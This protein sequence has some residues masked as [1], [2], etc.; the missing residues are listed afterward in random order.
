MIHT[1]TVHV[2][3]NGTITGSLLWP[4]AEVDASGNGV[5]WPGYRAAL[6]G[7]TPDWENLV[8]DPA[9]YGYGLRSG[10]TIDVH[11]NPTT[12]VSVAYPAATAACGEAPDNR[13]SSLVLDKSASTSFVAAGGTFDYTIASRNDGLG[14]VED[15]V[16]TDPVPGVL[17]ILSVTP[18][19]PTDPKAPAW[20]SCVVTARQGDGYGGTVTCDLDRPLGSGV[21]APDIVLH[22]QLS[23][24]APGGAIMNVAQLT[25]K[26]SPSN[27][28]VRPGGLTTF[29]LTDDAVILSAAALAMTGVTVTLGLQLMAS[30]LGAG[31]VLVL[32]ARFRRRGLSRG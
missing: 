28:A 30:L 26:E 1:D 6:P 22:V 13:S 9:A 16:M 25:G 8:L 10:A 3:A 23:P 14:A 19:V 11:I 20:S 31:L 24:K 17:R 21:A 2:T 27:A 4:G 7:E 29:D 12:T 15:L 32:I 5:M 18:V